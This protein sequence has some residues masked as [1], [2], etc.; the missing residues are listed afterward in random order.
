MFTFY[1]SSAGISQRLLSVG[2]SEN[3]H[4]TMPH[5]RRD[6]QDTEVTFKFAADATAEHPYASTGYGRGAYVCAL[7]RP[8]RPSRLVPWLGEIVC[9]WNLMS[10]P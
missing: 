10:Q 8:G 5:S 4:K 2:A 9:V 1:P 7:P 3:T 6:A